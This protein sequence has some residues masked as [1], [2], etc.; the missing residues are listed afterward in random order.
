MMTIPKLTVITL[1]VAS[2]GACGAEPPPP[3]PAGPVSTV[4]EATKRPVGHAVLVR[5]EFTGFGYETNSRRAF[6]DSEAPCPGGGAF[7]VA[8]LASEAEAKKLWNLQPRDRRRGKPG[9]KVTVS[10][11]IAKVEDGR[12]VEIESAVVRE[13]DR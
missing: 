5:G 1:M 2:A 7:L 12:S 9:G 11:R 13:V 6:L 4:C 10:G 8:D 3:D